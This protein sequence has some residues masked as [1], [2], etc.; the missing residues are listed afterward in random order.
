M[1]TPAAAVAPTSAGS[2]QGD[3]PQIL[4]AVVAALTPVAASVQS[5]APQRVLV[6]TLSATVLPGWSVARKV[7]TEIVLNAPE[8]GGS[9]TLFSSGKAANALLAQEADALL[10][11][12]RRDTPDVTWCSGWQP[13]AQAVTELQ[14]AL[15]STAHPQGMAP[16]QQ[17]AFWSVRTNTVGTVFYGYG[18]VGQAQQLSALAALAAPVIA[19]T[20]WK[21]K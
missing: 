7:G 12:A 4:S 21:L 16:Y 8:H 20:E 3:A 10:G 2:S 18:L 14:F 15:C 11:D 9:L 19:S 6:D 17:I 1:P 5:E 13:P